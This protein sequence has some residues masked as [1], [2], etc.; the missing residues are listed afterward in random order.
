MPNKHLVSVF[1][2]PS[3]TGL[4]VPAE[5]LA[6]QVGRSPQRS[7]RRGAQGSRG[8]RGNMEQMNSGGGKGRGNASDMAW[9]TQQTL[10]MWLAGCQGEGDPP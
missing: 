3:S 7:G 2:P 8:Q 6:S 5:Q 1:H 10:L 4:T 9:R